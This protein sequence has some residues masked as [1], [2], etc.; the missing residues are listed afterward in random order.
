MSKVQQIE[1]INLSDL[2]F[3]AN[4][5]EA[6]TNSGSISF[7]DADYTL[8]SIERLEPLA[9]EAEDSDIALVEEV[10]SK[11]GDGVMINLEG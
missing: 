5:L 4:F 9:E 1:Y 10:I 11:Y 6:L 3:S 8:V 2:F 7:G